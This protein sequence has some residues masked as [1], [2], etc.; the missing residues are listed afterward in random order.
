LR[1]KLAAYAAQA[2]CVDLNYPF[3]A[4]QQSIKSGIGANSLAQAFALLN[5]AAAIHILKNLAQIRSISTIAA[6]L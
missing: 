4:S 1:E 2:K 3:F 6:Y 5:E